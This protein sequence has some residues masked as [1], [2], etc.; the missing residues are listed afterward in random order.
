LAEQ[1]DDDDLR[2]EAHHSAWGRI[3]FGEF[4]VAQEHVKRGLALYSPAKHAAHAWTYTGHDPGVCAWAHRSSSLWFLGYSEQAAETAHRAVALAEQITHAPSVAHALN[5]GILYHQLQRD[6]ATV[7]AWA[8]RMT[9]LAAE[10][11]LALSEA[12]GTVARGWMLATEGQGAGAGVW[13]V[14]ST[15]ACAFTSLTTRH[16]VSKKPDAVQPVA[17]STNRKAVVPHR[18]RGFELG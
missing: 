12:I 16:W 4:A 17:R 15:W 7:R 11:R 18:L 8:D 13:L 3:W 2:L 14:V 6:R 9:T 10:H 1:A 5:H